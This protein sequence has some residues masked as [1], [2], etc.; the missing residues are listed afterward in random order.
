MQEFHEF[1]PTASFPNSQ[2]AAIIAAPMAWLLA[3]IPG[4]KNWNIKGDF[5]RKKLGFF[6]EPM[7]LGM[8]TGVVFGFWQALILST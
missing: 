2:N 3:R 8:I 6:A 1:N 5:V 7:V 4:I